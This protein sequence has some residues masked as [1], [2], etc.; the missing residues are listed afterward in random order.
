MTNSE[1]ERYV[2]G[3]AV[4][5]YAKYK[6]LPSVTIAQ[7]I[8][9]SGWGRSELATKANALFGIKAGKEWTG[10]RYNIKTKEVYD[11]KTVTEYADFRAYASW[12][13][14][15]LDH[16]EFLY[17]LSR[18]KNV[19][20]ETDYKKACQNLQKDGYATAPTYAQSL[21]DIIEDNGLFGY[22]E[23]AK[24]GMVETVPATIKRVQYVI[25]KGD[26]LT[27]IAEQHLTTVENLVKLNKITNKNLII[28]GDTL[29]LN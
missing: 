18:Y 26:T 2:A 1:F 27:K 11:G 15:I 28:A 24:R 3:Y 25:Q 12:G 10:K 19:I 13:D 20:G 23:T 7:A 9:E 6:I 14:S 22:D 16:N 21:I 4:N 8:L 5:S 17:N 29:Y